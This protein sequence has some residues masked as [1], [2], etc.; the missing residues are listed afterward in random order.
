MSCID[1]VIVTL[2]LV[3]C[4]WTFMRLLPVACMKLGVTAERR[5]SSVFVRSPLMWPVAASFT[6]FSR[7]RENEG[8][9]SGK[10]WRR[11]RCLPSASA[12]MST[13][14]RTA[15]F[16]A[17]HST[18]LELPWPTHPSTARTVPNLTFRHRHDGPMCH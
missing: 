1:P 16:A 5:V 7:C 6:V 15:S 9:A 10:R 14:V 8:A 12:K 3:R 11:D 13:S 18:L 2:W 4:G 17:H